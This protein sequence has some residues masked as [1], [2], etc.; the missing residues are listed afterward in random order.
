MTALRIYSPDSPTFATTRVTPPANWPA[1]TLRQI[2]DQHVRPELQQHAP[3]TI[4]EYESLLNDWERL[5]GNPPAS[6]LSRSTLV[7]FREQ[8]R[9]EKFRRSKISTPRLRSP[10]TI[11][12]KF[13]TLF[14]LIRLCWPKDSHNPGGL[15]LCDYFPLPK[16]LK[17]EQKL[18]FVFSHEELDR[19]YDAAGS[20]SWPARNAAI[21]WRTIFVL[22]YSTGPRTYDLLGL[23]WSDIDL[24][25]GPFGAVSFQASKTGKLQRIPLNR[26]TRAHLDQLRKSSRSKRLFPR[27]DYSNRST[28]LRNWR[29]LRAAAA[30]P[31]RARMEDFRKTCNTAYEDLSRG[32]GE[33]IL[34]HRLGGVNAQ[35]YYNPTNKV[36]DAVLALPLPSRFRSLD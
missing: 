9:Q 29:Q 17:E 14:P 23:E 35:N 2:F 24:E 27:F 3:K 28:I 26:S 34:G 8:L 22:H 30:L 33:W 32:V 19:L 7:E 31:E 21:I 6:E 25:F 1:P 5:T 11:N 12:K 4:E 36:L 13:R 10:A 15:G 20:A 18:P 16:R